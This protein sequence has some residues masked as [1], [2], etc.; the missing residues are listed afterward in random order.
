MKQNKK[1][2][3]R[4]ALKFLCNVFIAI[5]VFASFSYFSYFLPSA[6]I[7]P[8]TLEQELEKVKKERDKTKQQIEQAKKEVTDFTSQVDKV[9]G[10]L[11]NALADLDSLNGKLSLKKSEVDKLTIELVIQENE[12][13]EIEKLL[14]EKV[15]QL[16]SRVAVIYKSREQDVLQLLFETDS[17]LKFFSTLKLMSLVASQDSKIISEV[18][19]IKE[20]TVTARDDIEQLKSQ[21][22]TQ[23]RNLETLVS[24]AEKKKREI[25]GIYNE[26]KSLLSKA[27]ANKEALIKM[28]QKLAAKEAEIT[29]KLEALRYGNAPGRLAYPVRGI[30]TSGFG[31]RIS[32]I[33]G[34]LQFHSGVDIGADPGT[35]VIAAAS[36]QVLNAEYMGGYGYTVIIYHGGGFSTL[37][38]HLSGFAVGAGQNVKQG[39]I[40]GYVGSTGFST[41]PHL[42]FEVRV[43]GITRN[44]YSY[45]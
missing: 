22:R 1:Q 5:F 33:T 29:K 44:P 6:N 40:I 38:G 12:L 9:E 13:V 8:D 37:Y 24:D 42:H 28:E 18:Q 32:P 34:V 20:R 10:Q 39:Q 15:E 35:P 21:E 16:N 7:Y 3:T 11:V 17:F 31:N 45:F 23:K 14:K 2:E 19:G 4:S 41:G 27:R 25:E 26:K 36:G 30:L 43:N